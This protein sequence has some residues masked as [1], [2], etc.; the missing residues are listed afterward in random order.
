MNFS[1]FLI[2]FIFYSFMN[3][4]VPFAI[5]RVAVP[6]TGNEQFSPAPKQL[7]RGYRWALLM[8]V[9]V[10]MWLPTAAQAQGTAFSCDGTFYQIK[11][12]GS[13]SS[14]FK[15]DRSTANYKA[16]PVNV[17]TVN[18]VPTND[19]GVL[20]NGL[21]Y[22][23]QNGYMYA[24]TTNGINNTPPA[25]IDM[26]QIG[27][28][29][30]V[31]L[32]SVTGI[33][34]IQVASGTIDKNGFYYASSQ[35]SAAN[36]TDNYNLY[37][38]NLNAATLPLRLTATALRLRNSANTADA[39]LT[40]YDI[41]LNPKDNLL[42]GTFTNGTLWRIDANT[43]AATNQAAVTPIVGTGNTDPV[44]TAFF[45]VAGNLFVYTNGDVNTANSG[46]FYE[47]DT[48]TG[49]YSLISNISPASVS[50]GA[51]CINPDQRIDVV[52]E[53]T[54]LAP[55]GTTRQ[56]TARFAI[57]VKNTGTSTATNV[58]VSDFLRNGSATTFPT[59]STVTLGT[60]HTVTN[61]AA[62]GGPT[63]PTLAFNNTY[64]GQDNNADLLTGT[65]SLTA[66]QSALI[67]FSVVV[68]FPR[69]PGVPTSASLNSAYASSVSGTAGDQGSILL[70][71][72]TVIPPGNL[73]AFDQSTNTGALPPV[74]NDDTPTAT[75]I[76]F[77]PGILGSVF[78]DANYGGGAG[79]SQATSGGQGVV[80][81]VELYNATGVYLTA[82]NADADG[83]Y[84]FVDGVNNLTLASNTTY[85]VRV[86]S[87]TVVSAR[88]G[89][90]A[91]SQVPV[92]T[93][94]YNGTATGDV[95]RVGGQA[96]NKADYGTRTTALP[97]S[98]VSST[99]EIQSIASVTMPASGPVTNVDFGFNF[100][101]ITNTNDSGQ[102][103]LRQFILNSNALGSEAT[104]A[105][106]YTPTTGA[107]TPLTTARETSIFMIPNG[108]AVAGQIAGLANQFTT[109]TGADKAATI[110][111]A[112]ALDDITG[113]FT[114][115]DGST[116][117][118]STGNSNT[119]VT[120][121][122]TGPEVIIDYNQQGGLY[123]IGSDVR[124]ASVGLNNA[125]NVDATVGNRRSAGVTIFGAAA[126]RAVITDITTLGNVRAGVR[127]EST[128]GVASV[129]VT[130]SVLSNNS[131]NTSDA[132][133]LELLGATNGTFTGN[134]MSNNKGY[135]I[136]M[137]TNA[138]A[139]N[140]I[141]NNTIKGNGTGGSAANAG[142]NI[143]KGDNNLFSKNIITGN[144]GDG[145]VAMS[146]TSG[147]RFTQNSISANGGSTAQRD[148]GI[149]LLQPNATATTD[150]VTLNADGKTAAS[151]ANG[152]LN[153]PVFTQAT[154][155]NGMLYVSG[156]V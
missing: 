7:R 101:T 72:G 25:T 48:A 114:A 95:N 82:T 108:S 69:N 131:A 144:A 91:G 77:T 126:A 57:R 155:N 133:G 12:V 47:V 150:G 97:L 143:A 148:L 80:A 3:T 6:A 92:Q 30:I 113:S 52:K 130:N 68:T 105:Q 149:D 61:Y 119:A 23:P 59:A 49:N 111:L 104:L 65:Q 22:N 74:A 13:T 56:Y 16:V 73:L 54:S 107:V 29:G 8:L 137:V 11:Q 85:K 38:L 145:I 37:R 35:N 36:G 138:N 136:F 75:P 2:L 132:D 151:G 152:L 128:T 106:V 60:I 39:N 88:P 76:Y 135:G 146:G 110:T 18:G 123:V 41:A 26:Y 142:I 43:Y 55:T 109:T 45:D 46:A 121:T 90:A 40:F 20:L 127:I 83:N 51:S 153:F 14:L 156:Y 79:R 125:K 44:G 15:V 122:T 139:G 1:I 64:N 10:A 17:R 5:T 84:S 24:L 27:Q 89:G 86:V 62:V 147:N 34:N 94:I 154:I 50:D 115:I 96:P 99:N 129:S 124:V 63:A 118:R 70:P 53:L 21:A 67:D 98:A 78:E 140:N 141:S 103:S 112:T 58:Q 100:S 134:V 28:T 93:F 33:N 42:Y 31:K 32:G 19:L 66:G 102:G 9:W 4:Y 71:N 116:Q 87:N 117:T 81:R 120:G